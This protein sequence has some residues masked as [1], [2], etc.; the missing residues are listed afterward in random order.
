MKKMTLAG[1][2][3]SAASLV[4]AME[5]DGKP[6]PVATFENTPAGHRKLG[7]R[8]IAGGRTARVCLEATGIY[9]LDLALSMHATKGIALMVANPR[10]TKDF[11]RAFMQR[12]KTDT[13]DAAS[14][15]EFLRRMPFQ[16]WTAPEPD[17]L[18]FRA[19]ARRINA[20]V[21]T[22]AQERNRLHAGSRC[23]GLTDVLRIEGEAHIAY[24]EESIARLTEQAVRIVGANPSLRSKFAHLVSAWHRDPERGPDSGRADCPA[25][26]HDRAP[27]GCSC[28]PRSSTL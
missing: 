1:I 25:P 13:V 11:A 10:A 28:R 3:V 23:R 21:T 12:A 5:R 9:S 17:I 4:V 18:D 7:R 19:L 14:I 2:D 6:L 15:L 8:L 24:L 27:V 16:P 22:Q 20:P 26:G